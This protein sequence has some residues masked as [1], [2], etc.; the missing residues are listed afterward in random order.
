MFRISHSRL[1]R[2]E[3]CPR[4]A[5]FTQESAPAG[6]VDPKI[7]TAQAIG[8]LTHETIKRILAGVDRISAYSREAVDEALDTE[9]AS[10][11]P[12]P[13][14]SI[15]KAARLLLSRWRLF[16]TPLVG[17]QVL[18][19]EKGFTF[20]SGPD[21]EVFGVYDLVVRTQAGQLTVV[22]WKT[23][24]RR[25][26][27]EDQVILYAIAARRGF[28]NDQG[29]V[30]ALIY[31]F[32]ASNTRPMLFDESRISMET[33][34]LQR[35]IEGLRRELESFPVR[36]RPGWMCAACSKLPICPEGTAFVSAS[37]LRRRTLQ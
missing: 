36:A 17:A 33:V 2:G 29:G 12:R 6:P 8:T 7:A 30:H 32:D 20:Q 5:A 13:D 10:R 4:A 14:A 9:C 27:H 35:R 31:E 15:E 26:G 18:A 3:T 23:G 34:R 16:L 37:R 21:I 11:S 24:T 25:G 28:S 22:E 1:K 19:V